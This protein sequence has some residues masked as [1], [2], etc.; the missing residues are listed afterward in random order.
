MAFHPDFWGRASENS[1]QAFDAYGIPFPP[2][3]DRVSALAESLHVLRAVW[4]EPNP[5][6]AGEFY[7]VNGAVCDTYQLAV[8]VGP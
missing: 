7:T 6:Y 2:V 1:S 8:L 5:T 3:R 4:T